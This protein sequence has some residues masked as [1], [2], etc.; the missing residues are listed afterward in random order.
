MKYICT[1]DFSLQMYDEDGS[2]M[3]GELLE[4]HKGD[5]FSLNESNF[6]VLG[7]EVRLENEKTWLELTADDLARCFSA[8]E[9]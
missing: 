9:E 3:E 8:V 1:E 2:I 6:R 4:V 5:I 7:T